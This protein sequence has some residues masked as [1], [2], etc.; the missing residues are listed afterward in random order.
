MTT[1]SHPSFGSPSF[2]LVAKGLIALHRLIREGNDETTEAE[3]V[4]DFMDSSLRALCHTERERARWLSEDM[5]SISESPSTANLTPM[6]VQSQQQLNEAYEARQT[7]EWDRALSLLRR[8]QEYISPD[9]VSYLRG[10]IW[11][12]AGNPDV[13]TEFY[14]HAL[15][16]DSTNANYT[17]IYLYSLSKSDPKAAAMFAEEVL[18]RCA[19]SLQ[20][21]DTD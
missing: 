20:S 6:T 5:Y 7:G 15:E 13:A 12:E 17:A 14:R 9:L 2:Q 8:C 3:H 4:R 16:F 18:S 10:S 21:Y 11:L 1:V 19:K